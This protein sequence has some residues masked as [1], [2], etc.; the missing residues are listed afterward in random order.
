MTFSELQSLAK[1]P[2]NLSPL[3]QAMWHEHQ[4]E[5]EASHTLAQDVNTPD[6]SWVHAYLHRKEGDISNARYWYHQA[7]RQMP[8]I[9]LEKEWEAIVTALLE[10]E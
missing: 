2:K 3:L 9:S 5:W 1:S 4:G 6:G 10:K 7:G 8:T